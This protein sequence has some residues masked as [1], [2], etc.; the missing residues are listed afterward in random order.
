MFT[1]KAVGYFILASI[2]LLL[3]VVLEDWQIAILVLPLASLFFLTN[4]FGL[5]E[6][7]SLRLDQR[8]IPAETSFQPRLLEMKRCA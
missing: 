3:A 6:N 7:V 5:P 8:I 2:L 1:R 4:V